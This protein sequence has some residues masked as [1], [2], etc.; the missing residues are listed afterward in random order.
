LKISLIVATLNEIRRLPRLIASVAG[1]TYP[2]ELVEVVIADGGSTDGTVEYAESAG[3][4]VVHNPHRR[5]EPGIVVGTGVATGDLVASL[6][7]DT[8]FHDR[9]F[10][11]KIVAPFA[12]PNVYL[13][14][15]RVIGTQEDCLATRYI[16]EFT[17][18]FNHFLYGDAASP[19]TFGLAYRI[20]R[21]TPA[22]VI[23]DFPPDAPPLVAFAQGTTLRAGFARRTGTEEDDILPVMDVLR[24]GGEI[25]YVPSARIEHHT[26][27]S[28]ADFVQKF[29]PRIAKR[30]EDRSHT[31]WQR[32][33]FWT[34]QR[35]MRAYLWPFYAVS[36][37]GP[38]L[39]AL[40]GLI[41]DRRAIWLYH[42]VI[43]F[44]LGIEFWRRAVP[45]A[46]SLALCRL[47]GETGR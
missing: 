35:R 20:K 19:T 34:K 44:A 12:D 18:P 6:A 7:A 23:Y 9:D 16:N 1:Q 30:L 22:Y 13:S 43:T 10:I 38:I 39:T 5:A 33:A 46:W 21:T 40:Y 14:V 26:V 29:G 25:A 4:I 45:Y 24:E 47:R 28:L 8:V 2:R 3:C 15:P 27:A 11:A 36:V 37:V 42:P 41:R 31:V 32:A 17:D